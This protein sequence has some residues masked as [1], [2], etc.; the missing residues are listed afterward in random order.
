MDY[1]YKGVPGYFQRKGHEIIHNWSKEVINRVVLEVGCGHGHHLEFGT[2][3]KT[4]IGLD[5]SYSF[6]KTAVG[7][8]A[9][10][11]IP[12][13]GNAYGLPFRDNAIDVV[14]SVYNLEHLKQLNLALK[15]IKRVLKPHGVL[16]IGIPCEGGF[17]YN[18]GREFSSKPHMEKKYGI[19]YDAIIRFEHCN[20]IWDILSSIKSE[21]IIIKSK[22]IPFRLPSYH[23]NVISCFKCVVHK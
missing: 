17:L 20:E 10:K 13:Q 9:N 15:E 18:V 6:L 5:I 11:V 23:L 21:F 1:L 16:L 22:W 4:Y 2:G 3:Y 19:D 12:V 14:V 7:R 8:Y